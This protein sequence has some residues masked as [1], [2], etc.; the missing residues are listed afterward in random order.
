MISLRYVPSDLKVEKVDGGPIRAV[1][2]HM[3]ELS[4]MATS[5]DLD[6]VVLLVGNLHEAGREAV[7]VGKTGD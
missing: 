2:V 5:F 4:P 1:G 3:A 7:G 6:G